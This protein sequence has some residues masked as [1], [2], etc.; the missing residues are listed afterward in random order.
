MSDRDHGKSQRIRLIDVFLLGPYLIWVA[1]RPN[2]LRHT[3]RVLITGIGIATIVY[4]WTNY[5]RINSAD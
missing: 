3:D 4:N 5:Q 2:R 1:N